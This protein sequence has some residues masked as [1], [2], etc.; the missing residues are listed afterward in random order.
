MARFWDALALRQRT[1]TIGGTGIPP[2]NRVP[3]MTLFA[4]RNQ[5]VVPRFRLSTATVDW[6]SSPG[7]GR[8]LAAR[9]V[10]T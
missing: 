2:N 10:S 3:S 8:G 6:C 4:T 1:A 7:D 5:L 9:I